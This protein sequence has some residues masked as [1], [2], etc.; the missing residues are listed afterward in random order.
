MTRN[1]AADLIG[2]PEQSEL[3]NKETDIVQYLSANHDDDLVF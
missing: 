1:R 3:T 2:M